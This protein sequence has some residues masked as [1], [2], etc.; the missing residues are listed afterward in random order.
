MQKSI[1]HIIVY[2]SA[3]C[4]MQSN[5]TYVTNTLYCLCT[6]LNFPLSSL[7]CLH[8]DQCCRLVSSSY[9][10]WECCSGALVQS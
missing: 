6:M 9:S 8:Q 3:K 7:L 5:I 10:G 1:Y 4:Y 2:S